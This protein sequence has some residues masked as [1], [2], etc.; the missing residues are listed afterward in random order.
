[1]S[2]R[3]ESGLHKNDSNWL[4][5]ITRWAVWDTTTQQESM[6]SLVDLGF[7][8]PNLRRRLGLQAKMALLVAQR[9]TEDQPEARFVYCS[10]HGELSRT[11]T[12][13]ADL[14]SD[15]TLSPTAFSMSVL[16]STPSLFSIL[17]RNTA[18]TPAISAAESSFGFGLLEACLQLE[19]LPEQPVVLVYADE[20]L[21]SSYGESEDS[22]FQAHAF[23]MLL[24][25]GAAKQVKCHLSSGDG[26]S[27]SQTQSRAFMRCLETGHATWQGEGRTWTWETIRE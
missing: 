12:M 20:P 19:A 7:I 22:K 25:T 21:P 9:C 24:Q 1:M 17:R 26:R 16:S 23:A 6:P 5:P 18:P 14:A 8:E 27:D 13:L 15:E 11:V 4:I 10:R 2:K 3:E